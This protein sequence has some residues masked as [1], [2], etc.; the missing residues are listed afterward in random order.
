MSDSFMDLR[1]WQKAM[2]LAEEIYRETATF[3]REEIYNLTQQM[4]RSAIS[5]PSNIAEGKGRNS[6][7]EFSQF[8][9]HS[10]G[11]LLEL[12][13]QVMIAKRL[14]YFSEQ[15]AQQILEHAN[16]VGRSLSGLINSLAEMAVA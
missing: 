2:D 12:Q 5:V 1:V 8:L 10:R 14:N 9:F 7:R 15:Q 4:R 6:Q 13:T 11:S 16:V 3:P